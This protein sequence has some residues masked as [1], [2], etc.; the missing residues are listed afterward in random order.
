M[1]SPSEG[2]P[3]NVELQ[4]PPH[5]EF[6]VEALMKMVQGKVKKS[7]L[8]DQKSKQEAYENTYPCIEEFAK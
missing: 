8:E 1:S 4:N 7:K 5:R 6:A 2:S 3:E